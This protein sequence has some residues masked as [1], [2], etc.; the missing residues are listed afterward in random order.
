[1]LRGETIADHPQDF[2]NRVK[3]YARRLGA[4]L[5]G[6]TELN[7]LWIYSNRGEIFRENWE[8]WGKE[9]VVNHRFAI[10]FA[11][12]MHLDL[13][14]TAPHTPTVVESM[15][16]YSEGAYIATQLAAYITN[17]GHSAT[18]NHLRHYDT[19]LVPLSVESCKNIPAQADRRV[20]LAECA[21]KTRLHSWMTS[22]TV[23]SQGPKPDPNGPAT[24]P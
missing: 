23:E 7:T 22:F 15:C 16:N 4:D 17:L 11:T 19:V 6:I 24:A 5:V 10:V 21:R 1:M 9:I 3:G 13:V 8:D 14:T 18:A 20:S 2:S 12:E